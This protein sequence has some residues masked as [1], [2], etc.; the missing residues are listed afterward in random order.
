LFL[1]KQRARYLEIRSSLLTKTDD[2]QLKKTTPSTSGE[3]QTVQSALLEILKHP[4]KYRNDFQ[5]KK[6]ATVLKDA[7]FFKQRQM[8]PHV[9]IE[10]LKKMQIFQH[11][12]GQNVF[13]Y[14]DEGDL[15]YFVIRGSVEILI[16]DETCKEESEKVK[17]LIDELPITKLRISITLRQA[18]LLKVR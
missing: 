5:L 17:L 4:S 11:Q 13:E 7:R 16:P 6:I 9:I 1:A 18:K 8:A 15:F 12:A 3:P 10:M 2:L 14:G